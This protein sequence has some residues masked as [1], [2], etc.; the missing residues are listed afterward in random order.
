VEKFTL[1]YLCAR[2]LRAPQP[3]EAGRWHHLYNTRRW[4]RR[5]RLQLTEYPLC[6][7]CLAKNVVTAVAQPPSIR[8]PRAHPQGT[9]RVSKPTVRAH[10]HLAIVNARHS[11]LVKRYGESPDAE[12]RYSPAVCIGRWSKAIPTR[13]IAARPLPSGKI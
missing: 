6:S 10:D 1:V 7:M 8:R 5:A 3:A 12:K 13:T 9:P 4:R 2:T 11:R